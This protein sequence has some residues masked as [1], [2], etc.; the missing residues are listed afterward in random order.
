MLHAV[1]AWVEQNHFF[2]RTDTVDQ[3]LNI[4][5]TAVDK[6]DFGARRFWQLVGG[7]GAQQFIGEPLT[8]ANR[9]RAVVCR[10]LFNDRFRSGIGGDQGGAVEHNARFQCQDRLR[11][12]QSLLGTRGRSSA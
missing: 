7:E 12:G 10:L 3:G 8:D 4:V 2:V 6:H 11:G 5:H 1:T 9:Q